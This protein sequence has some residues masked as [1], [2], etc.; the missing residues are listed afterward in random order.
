M[1]RNRKALSGE[2]ASLAQVYPLHSLQHVVSG[3]PPQHP[4]EKTP[5][6][7]TLAAQSPSLASA[8]SP[9]SLWETAGAGP[10]DPGKPPSY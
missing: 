2:A 10:S 5:S 9:L 6:P 8:P 7:A 1:A 3:L 4:R